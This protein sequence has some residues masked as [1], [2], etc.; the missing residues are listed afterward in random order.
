MLAFL[1]LGGGWLLGAE[2]SDRAKLPEHEQKLQLIYTLAKYTE[3]PAEA[4]GGAEQAFVM[5]V[6]GDD[7]FGPATE[8][9]SKQTLKNR[10]IEVKPVRSTEEVAGCHVLFVSAGESK[11]SAELMEKCAGTHILTFG[12]SEDFER[13][14]GA[15]SFVKDGSLVRYIVNPKALKAAGLQMAPAVVQSGGRSK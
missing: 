1:T 14:G 12:D 4:L 13:R 10:P 6:L 7:L 3:W 15:V 5:G 8:L 9:L 11:L 2:K